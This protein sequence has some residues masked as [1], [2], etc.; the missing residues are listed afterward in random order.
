M[1]FNKTKFGLITAGLVPL[2]CLSI[3]ATLIDKPI[4][5][6]ETYSQNNHTVTLLVKKGDDLSSQVIPCYKNYALKVENISIKGIDYI[7]QLNSSNESI[8]P[9]T[10]I[11]IPFYQRTNSGDLHFNIQTDTTPWFFGMAKI[12]ITSNISNE[13]VFCNSNF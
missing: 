9:H 11:S 4:L 10:H 5:L 12:H 8:K 7:F 1:V 13:S 2:Y 3:R 6:E